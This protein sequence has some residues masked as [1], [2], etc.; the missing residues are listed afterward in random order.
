[1]VNDATGRPV[2]VKRSSGSAVRLPVTV[3]IGS[4]AMAVRCPFWWRVSGGGAAVAA[5]AVFGAGA[6]VRGP[7][8]LAAPLIGGRVLAGERRGLDRPR[9]VDGERGVGERG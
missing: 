7:A 4:L 9:L 3:V 8:R 1:M 6:E 2:A 5:P